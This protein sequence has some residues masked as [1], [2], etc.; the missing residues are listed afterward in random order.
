MSD[1]VIEKKMI[2]QRHGKGL[3]PYPFSFIKIINKSTNEVIGSGLSPDNQAT[4]NYDLFSSEYA[5][6]PQI[7]PNLEIDPSWIYSDLRA[8]GIL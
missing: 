2:M 8:T 1:E 5:G 4:I 6:E 3:R 7:S